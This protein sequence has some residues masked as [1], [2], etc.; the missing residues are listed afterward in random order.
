MQTT[1]KTRIPGSSA[2]L[3]VNCTI[4]NTHLNN[5]D[6]YETRPSS[7]AMN[8]HSSVYSLDIHKPTVGYVMLV[9]VSL[10][11]AFTILFI[12]LPV[13]L[14]FIKLNHCPL[15]ISC[16]F[17]IPGYLA[18]SPAWAVSRQPDVK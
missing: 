12:L 11:L 13:V 18:E 6:K 9:I 4:A 3:S 10:T 16:N 1:T 15:V 8:T 5:T 7:K 17:N 14:Q 2:F